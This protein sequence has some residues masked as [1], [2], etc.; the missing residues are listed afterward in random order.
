MPGSSEILRDRRAVLL[1]GGQT[2]SYDV[3]VLC[4]GA[5]ARRLALPGAGLAGVL[6]L[7]TLSDAARIR[8]AV[9]P[10]AGR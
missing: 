1:A 7:R 2:L 9:R 3:L 4:T 6:Y 5:G 10:A 8:A